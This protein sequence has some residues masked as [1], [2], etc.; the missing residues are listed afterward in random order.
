M[1]R[2][3]AD[4]ET[5]RI[6]QRETSRKFPAD[7]QRTALRKLWM[8]HAAVNVHDLR[9]PPGN[10]LEKLSGNRN[11]QYSIRINRQWRICFSW[12]ENTSYDVEITDYH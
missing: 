3:F 5:E 10:H 9:I 1:I 6:F 4:Q 2:N 7:I 11:G 8:L 12:K